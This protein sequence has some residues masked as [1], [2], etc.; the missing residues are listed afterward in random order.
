MIVGESG[1]P[2]L[3]MKLVDGRT[4]AEVIDGGGSDLASIYQLTTIMTKVCDAVQFAHEAGVVHGDLKP[5]NILIG[6]AGEVLVTDWGLSTLPREL[7]S[8]FSKRLAEMGLPSN[9]DAAGGIRG[10]PA[11]MA[12]E[13]AVGSPIDA[14]TD[15]FG[16][17]VILYQILTGVPL[18]E[19]MYV[20]HVVDCASRAEFVPPRVRA[21]EREIRPDLERLCCKALSLDPGARQQ[22]ALELAQSLGKAITDGCWFGLR[23]YR[24]GETIVREGEP[25]EEAFLIESGRC[26]VLQESAEGTKVLREMGPG[27]AFGEAGIFTGKARSATVVALGPVQV[28]C[29]DRESLKWAMSRQGPLAVLSRALANR[30]LEREREL[31]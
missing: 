23:S 4:L 14:R 19:G 18:Y 25:S 27:E 1:A 12:P 9:A 10:T 29:V 3:V 31:S 30:F 21:P 24:A 13:Q 28:Q 2:E 15:V 5:Q 6:R 26:Q 8:R 16:L 7:S 22:S 17:G 11:Y 20:P